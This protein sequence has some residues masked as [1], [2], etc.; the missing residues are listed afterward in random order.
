MTQWAAYSIAGP[1]S[2]GSASASPVRQ[3]QRREYEPS[4][5]QFGENGPS[6]LQ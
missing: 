4:E 6:E 2:I 5:D 3:Y 1:A